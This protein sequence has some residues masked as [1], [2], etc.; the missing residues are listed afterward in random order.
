M[1]K[2]SHCGFNA[3]I[4]DTAPYEVLMCDKYIQ[5]QEFGDY[6]A[7]IGRVS[8]KR[9]ELTAIKASLDPCVIAEAIVDDGWLSQ[10]ADMSARAWL[11]GE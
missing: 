1:I 5:G 6:V 2:V 8:D 10:R 9:D 3:Y 4:S 11:R 7:F